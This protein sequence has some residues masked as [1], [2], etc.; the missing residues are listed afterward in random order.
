[1]SLPSSDTQSFP[2]GLSIGSV[3]HLAEVAPVTLRYWEKLGLIQAR[4]TAGGHR[5]Y[6]PELLPLIIKIKFLLRD[7]KTR[8]SE[9]S[10]KLLEKS[11]VSSQDPEEFLLKHK[12][13]S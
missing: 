2:Q 1:M 5:L 9:V 10:P 11:G 3:A 4:R 7:G 12:G 13:L 8:A 6:A